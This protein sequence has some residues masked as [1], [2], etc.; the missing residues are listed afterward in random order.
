MRRDERGIASI[1]MLV[2][3]MLLALLLFGGIELG[4]GMSLKHALDVGTYNAVRYYSLTECDQATVEDIVKRE[5]QNNPLGGNPDDV[6]V[7]IILPD[8]PG[9]R[10]EV[11]IRS[12]MP[13]HASIPFMSLPVKTL[14]AEHTM[15]IE[16][17]Q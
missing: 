5:I 4:R 2:V 11:T 1:E 13:F 16:K 7:T 12:E 3:T 17:Y 15:L 6:T 10:H 14:R 8:G 9:F